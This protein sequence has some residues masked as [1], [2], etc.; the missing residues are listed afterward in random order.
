VKTTAANVDHPSGR[1][2]AAQIG[3]RS[4]GLVNGS[5]GAQHNHENGA[6]RKNKQ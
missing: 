2:I 6:D 5:S 4:H 3:G 1:R